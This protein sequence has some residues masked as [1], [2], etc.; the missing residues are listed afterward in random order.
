MKDTVIYHHGL[1]KAHAIHTPCIMLRWQPTSTI[2]PRMSK[3][4]KPRKTIQTGSLIN[5]H[6]SNQPSLL[7]SQWEQFRTRGWCLW[8]NTGL[9]RGFC[10]SLILILDEISMVD[11]KILFYIHGRLRQVQQ[12]RI[13][14]II[15]LLEM[16]AD[17]QLVTMMTSSWRHTF[18][19]FIC[20][21]TW[22]NKPITK[23]ISK[24][25][26]TVADIWLEG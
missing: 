22:P 6:L 19:K 2:N 5:E 23:R 25:A 17:I 4:S 12:S 16:W 24:L 10:G 21:Y 18:F 11:Q 26:C 7:A 14:I 9:F 15:I 20:K 3:L 13:G 8:T 1:D